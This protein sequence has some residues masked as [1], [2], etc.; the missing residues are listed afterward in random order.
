MDLGGS[1]EMFQERCDGFGTAKIIG[2]WMGADD[3]TDRVAAV[4]DR[5][6]CFLADMTPTV[7]KRSV[8]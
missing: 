3:R 6:E 2:S 5:N 4:P 8:R 1:I 7:E